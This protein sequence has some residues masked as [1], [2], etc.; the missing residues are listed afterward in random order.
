MFGVVSRNEIEGIGTVWFLG[1]DEVFGCAR[2]LLTLG[3]AV[4]SAMHRRFRRLENMVSTEN[5]AAIRLLKAWGFELGSE[6]MDV[7]GVEFRPFWREV[8]DV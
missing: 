2:E 7:N 6:T 1:T 3:P 4:I 8:A 5:A